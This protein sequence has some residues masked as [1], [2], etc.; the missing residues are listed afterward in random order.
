MN[1]HIVIFLTPPPLSLSFFLFL[2][3]GGGTY[4]DVSVQTI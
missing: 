4:S 1:I 3:G 2:E